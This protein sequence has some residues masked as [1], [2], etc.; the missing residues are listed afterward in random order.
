MGLNF[1]HVFEFVHVLVNSELLFSCF[2]YTY[3]LAIYIVSVYT[4]ITRHICTDGILISGLGVLSPCLES[5]DALRVTV[6]TVFLLQY[7]NKWLGALVLLNFPHC[8]CVCVL[9][10]CAVC[11]SDWHPICSE[12]CLV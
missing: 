4:L 2:M 11:V 12:A 10:V 5:L 9:C 8:D 7:K 6:A 3:T 1:K